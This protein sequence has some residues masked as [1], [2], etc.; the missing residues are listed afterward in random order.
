M[1][2][3]ITNNLI[4]SYLERLGHAAAPGRL[5]ILGLRGADCLGPTTITRNRNE[6]NRYN[7]TICLF[8]THLECFRATVDPGRTWTRNPSNPKGAAH[9]E[10]GRWQYR[11]GPHRK[12][13]AL[14]QAGPVVVRRDRDRDDLAEPGEPLDRGWFG[15]NIHAGGTAPTVDAWSAGCQ[16]IAGGWTGKPWTRFYRL[17]KASGQGEFEY[18]LVDAKGLL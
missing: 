15:I 2:I 4:R 9:L 11:F 8:G 12:R 14:V 10:N 13:P 1:A 7:D 5:H 16:V 3:E 18:F 17:L 6:P